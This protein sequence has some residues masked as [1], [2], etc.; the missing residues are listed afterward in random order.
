MRANDQ[1][2]QIAIDQI[3]L[4]VLSVDGSTGLVMKLKRIT[5]NQKLINI[6]PKIATRKMKNGYLAVSVWRENKQYTLYAHRLIWIYHT[7][8]I[9]DGYD[10]NHINGKKQDNRLENLELM[11]RGENLTHALRTGLRKA[12]IARTPIG[13]ANRVIDLKSSGLSYSKIARRLGISQTTA[14]RAVH[15]NLPEQIQEVKVG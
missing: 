5:G 12:P 1:K 6:E 11:T 8:P 10:I 2:I 15:G 13:I 7:A 14:F 4:G 9:P 3:N